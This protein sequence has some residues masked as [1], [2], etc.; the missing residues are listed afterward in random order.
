MFVKNCVY[1]FFSFLQFD[2]LVFISPNFS[3]NNLLM[4]YL[5]LQIQKFSMKLH[6]LVILHTFFYS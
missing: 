1:C 3:F 4:D 2:N 5:N 6:N